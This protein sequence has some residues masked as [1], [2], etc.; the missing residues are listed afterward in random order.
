MR[1]R[2]LLIGE[3]H[4]DPRPRHQPLAA[5]QWSGGW[6][7]RASRRCPP[8]SSMARSPRFRRAPA[9][10]GDEP[11]LRRVDRR[12]PRDRSLHRRLAAGRGTARLHHQRALRRPFQRSSCSTISAA[13]TISSRARVR[14]IGEPLQRIAE[15][16]LRILRYFR[17]HARYGHGEPDAAGARGLHRPGQ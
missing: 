11:P 9:G 7:P 5:G 15:D 2:D 16:H 12:P 4:S 6:R 17:F 8:A 10:R 13:S 14:F 3:E 1:L